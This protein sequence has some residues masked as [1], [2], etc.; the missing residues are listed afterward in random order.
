MEKN[1]FAVLGI[2]PDILRGLTNSQIGELV[3]GVSKTLQKICHPDKS[4]S[5]RLNA[6]SGQISEAN[7]FLDQKKHPDAFQHY[8]EAFLK[9]TPLKER[10]SELE[11]SVAISRKRLS[12]SYG[13]LYDIFSNRHNFS[14]VLRVHNPWIVHPSGIRWV[15]TT[16]N[17]NCFSIMTILENKVVAIDGSPEME[18]AKRIIGSIEEGV[19]KNTVSP[20]L[21]QSFNDVKRRGQIASSQ[22]RSGEKPRYHGPVFTKD[23]F[24]VIGPYINY[25]VF[26]KGYL[27]T[28]SQKENISFIQ[29]EGL[30]R[31]QLSTSTISPSA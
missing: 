24:P 31:E 6:R 27:V 8:L 12:A 9:K 5:S 21:K 11:Q 10:M 13:H 26:N 18:Y 14:G 1:P 23:L 16:K 17:I 28:M 4:S 3:N 15:A 7:E 30:V 25:A 22:A 2:S 19:Y 29:I 20:L